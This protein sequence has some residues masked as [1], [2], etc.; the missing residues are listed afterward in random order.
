MSSSGARSKMTMRAVVQQ[1]TTTTRDA[2]NQ[3]AAPTWT[4]YIASLPC[5]VWSPSG[6]RTGK[7]LVHDSD[8]QA[9]IEGPRMIVPVTT[10]ITESH[11]VAN[12]ADRLG[13]VLFAG[14]FIIDTVQR[15]PSHL[16][17]QLRQVD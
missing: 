2:M 13:N 1:N 11:R 12:V 5:Y 14:P 10:S 16:E 8:K 3:P 4:T 9:L 17:L 6:A 15:K 7:V